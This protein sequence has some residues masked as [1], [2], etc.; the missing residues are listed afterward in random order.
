MLSHASFMADDAAGVGKSPNLMLHN[1]TILAWATAGNAAEQ[2]LQALS[3]AEYVDA[4]CTACL[5]S[6]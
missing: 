4:T 5:Q 1:V 2:E 6:L 3:H